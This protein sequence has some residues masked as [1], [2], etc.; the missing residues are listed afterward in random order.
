MGI[1]PIRE[2]YSEDTVFTSTSFTS[3]PGPEGG[4]KSAD[5]QD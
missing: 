5:D 4:T 1:T 2:K 3:A